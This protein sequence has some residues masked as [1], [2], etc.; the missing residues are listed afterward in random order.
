[1]TLV[2]TGFTWKM[3]RYSHKVQVN[4]SN[5]FN[6]EFTYGSGAPGAPF[7]LFAQYSVGF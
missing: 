2:G 1:M 4:V 5:L 7:Q 3:G 6:R